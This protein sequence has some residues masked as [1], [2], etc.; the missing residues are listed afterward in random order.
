[1]GHLYKLDFAGGKSYIGITTK[2]CHRRFGNHKDAA[3]RG[4]AT[5][6]YNAWRKYGDP[7]LTVLAVVEDSDL[8]QAE[9]RAIKAFNTLVPNGY[10]TLEGG[11]VSPMNNEESRGK[12]AAAQKAVWSNQEYRDK[13]LSARTG[14]KRSDESRKRMSES[15]KRY[16][17][18]LRKEQA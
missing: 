4:V 5:P 17:E 10:N 2:T 14:K 15:K 16:Y 18:Q 11:Q 13:V 12:V 3:R 9:I 1:M 8:A 6:L 7:T